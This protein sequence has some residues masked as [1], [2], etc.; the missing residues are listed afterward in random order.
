MLKN[1]ILVAFGGGI[2]SILRY[3]SNIGVAYYFP[4]R[5]YIA[6]FIINC[7]GCLLIGLGIGYI[8]KNSSVDHTSLKM[9]FLTGFCGGFTTFS[10][11]GLENFNLL[12]NHNLLIS[13]LYIIFSIILGIL[14]VGIGI[15]LIK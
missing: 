12:Q 11:F 6:T 14:C 10:T 9:F 3:L 1:I 8:Q 15:Y 7:L 4:S 5:N 2:G 13:L